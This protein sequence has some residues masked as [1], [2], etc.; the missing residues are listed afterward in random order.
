MEQDELMEML[1]ADGFDPNAAE[2]EI[3]IDPPAAPEMVISQAHPA[4]AGDE[5]PT[6]MRVL[7]SLPLEERVEAFEIAQALEVSPQSDQLLYSVLVGLGLH[8]TILKGVP[9]RIAEAGQQAKGGFNDAASKVKTDIAMALSE[10]AGSVIQAGEQANAQLQKT[11][12]ACAAQIQIAAGKGAQSAV[13]S[14]DVTPIVE[15]AISK[16]ASKTESALAKKW[17]SRAV[18]ISSISAVLIA[19]GAGYSGYKIAG[20][21]N[22]GNG[23]SSSGD[24]YLNQLQCSAAAN[25]VIPCRDQFG[26]LV[27]FRSK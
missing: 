21:F 24:F 20:L 6:L 7:R 19:G 4:T 22:S 25:G 2:E 26:N 17:F 8:K 1:M 13:S 27:K 9:D 23:N 5:L 11:L 16:I 10:G 3:D 18:I 15:S 12:N 14:M